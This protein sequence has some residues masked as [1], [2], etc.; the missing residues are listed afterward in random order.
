[1]RLSTEGR[2]I[3][4]LQLARDT[5]H[6]SEKFRFLSKVIVFLKKSHPEADHV[7]QNVSSFFK[8]SMTFSKRLRLDQCLIDF[9]LVQN[10]HVFSKTYLFGSVSDR[11]TIG[12]ALW[13][14]WKICR[15]KIE[16]CL[17]QFYKKFTKMLQTCWYNFWV[18]VF[19]VLPPDP[20]FT[21]F[22]KA[23]GSAELTC[24]CAPTFPSLRWR[25]IW[26]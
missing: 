11:F 4:R 25:V 9:P 13:Q 16:K 21:Q 26:W 1:M 20:L 6:F 22:C 17:Q 5:C 23:P 24:F 14:I 19:H 7:F 12:S 10:I 3:D 15:K 8:T 2:C 18:S